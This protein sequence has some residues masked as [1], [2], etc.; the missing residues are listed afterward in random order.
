MEH[1]F[2]WCFWYHTIV[3]WYVWVCVLCISWKTNGLFFVHQLHLRIT[4]FRD[5]QLF[6]PVLLVFYF[7]YHFAFVEKL[8]IYSLVQCLRF[9]VK[10]LHFFM[11]KLRT[12]NEASNRKFYLR[13]LCFIR[14]GSNG[15]EFFFFLFTV[16]IWFTTRALGI[17]LS[18][19]R[20]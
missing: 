6:Y 3:G 18:K 7:L 15:R 12:K 19:N 10:L 5:L 1:G 13:H 2:L 4:H 9:T 11:R 14:S 8:R 16:Q 20:S 17:F